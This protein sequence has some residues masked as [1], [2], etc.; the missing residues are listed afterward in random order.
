M[1]RLYSIG[2]LIM[3]MAF[4]CACGVE[5]G[6]KVPE[7]SL[8]FRST[9]SGSPNDADADG[10]SGGQ[11]QFVAG[12][13]SQDAIL[14]ADGSVYV[15][16]GY[17]EQIGSKLVAN[18]TVLKFLADGSL[19]TSYDPGGSYRSLYGPLD[20]DIV[21]IDV[22]A[23]GEALVLGLVT[24]DDEETGKFDTHYELYSF[25]GAGELNLAFDKDGSLFMGD[26]VDKI[27]RW[28]GDGILV[29]NSAKLS[30]D[31]KEDATFKG[32]NSAP[33]SPETFVL[34]SDGS[35]FVGGA[36][37]SRFDA[38]GLESSASSEFSNDRL[39]GSVDNGQSI[40]T[41][42]ESGGQASLKKYLP[43]GA[44]IEAATVALP[45]LTPMTPTSV[46]M[47]SDRIMLHEQTQEGK[48]RRA[49]FVV[50]GADGAQD[51]AFGT[52]GTCT[53]GTGEQNVYRLLLLPT[54]NVLALGS[55]EAGGFIAHLDKTCAPVP[56]P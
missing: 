51:P 31:G 32:V 7:E 15:G 4:F 10:Y 50:F 8:G 22:N 9:P 42:R 13:G 38:S 3:P 18:R 27:V 20:I 23:A 35:F 28:A 46:Q 25:D 47:R 39:L 2:R 1:N 14:G 21:S 34:N 36:T 43:T 52:N 41:Y 30:K 26:D 45:W 17:Y 49:K 48:L 53:Y 40:L 24:D 19:D 56:V 37:I 29:G 16:T 5:K 12:M 55:D 33:S 54:G 44:P 11:F 6:G